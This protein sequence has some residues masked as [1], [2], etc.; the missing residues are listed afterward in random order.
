MERHARTY[1]T[2]LINED[3]REELEALLEDMKLWDQDDFTQ[4]VRDVATRKLELK[5]KI[6]DRTYQSA[7]IKALHKAN[8]KLN[9]ST[10]EGMEQLRIN[11]GLINELN[12]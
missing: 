1:A 3:L 5:K 6:A 7:R 2:H 10:K 12:N 8:T 4:V 9:L 11:K